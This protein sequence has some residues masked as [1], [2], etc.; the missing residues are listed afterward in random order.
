MKKTLILF[1]LPLLAFTTAHKFYLSVTNVYY[2]E[3][4]DALQ[5]TTR[6]FIDDLEEVMQERYGI[7]PGLATEEEVASIADRYIEKYLRTKFLVALD[8]APAKF[9]FLGKR[10]DTDV[11]IC[12]LELKK[13]NFDSLASITVQNEVL[14]DLFP[15]QKNIVHFKWKENK[16]S[17][18]LTKENNKGMLNL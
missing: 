5:I 12:Y 6:I 2:A 15:E 13:V 10:Y 18:L 7:K 9:V 1:L 3:E 16:K 8:G 17:F 14:T 4:E 11:V